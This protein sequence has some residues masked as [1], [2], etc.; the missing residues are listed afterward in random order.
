MEFQVM[1]IVDEEVVIYWL[2]LS[3]PRNIEDLLK[4]AGYGVY[5]WLQACCGIFSVFLTFSF[6]DLI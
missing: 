4:S 2:I 5:L 1:I 6:L 3:H